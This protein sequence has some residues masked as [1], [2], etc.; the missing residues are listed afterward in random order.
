MMITYAISFNDVMT[1]YGT[2][3][4]QESFFIEMATGIINAECEKGAKY[5]D[6]VYVNNRPVIFVFEIEE[7]KL[8]ANQERYGQETPRLKRRY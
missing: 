5:V 3:K 1:T 6:T 7:S 2:A 8:K 4:T